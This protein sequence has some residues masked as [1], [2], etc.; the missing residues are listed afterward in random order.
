MRAFEKGRITDEPS[1]GDRW[2]ALTAD[3]G[4]RFI[5]ATFDPYISLKDY[6]PTVYM[7]TRIA[8]TSAGA[9]RQ[10]MTDGLLKFKGAA[11]AMLRRNGGI[12][13]I[14]EGLNGEG[15]DFLWWVAGHRAETLA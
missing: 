10:F 11:Y 2:Q 4:R 5:R 1:W 3:I 13:G 8:N 6:D 12:R 15:T 9:T 14:M 7:A